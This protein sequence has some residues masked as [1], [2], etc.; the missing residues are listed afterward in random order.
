MGFVFLFTYSK[1]QSFLT[2]IDLGL[3][4]VSLF[5]KHIGHS[6]IPYC[7]SQQR[8]KAAFKVVNET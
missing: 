1:M 5:E 8:S 6:V 7:V 4:I 2:D 3:L